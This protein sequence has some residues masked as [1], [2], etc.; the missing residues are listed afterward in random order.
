MS[1]PLCNLQMGIAKLTL[2][3]FPSSLCSVMKGEQHLEAYASNCCELNSSRLQTVRLAAT[4]PVHHSI[5][6]CRLTIKANQARADQRERTTSPQKFRHV[7]RGSS[8]PEA[9]HSIREQPD[10]GHIN[11][12]GSTE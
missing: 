3:V 5:V 12:G 2:E 8:D 11:E 6:L 9:D 4:Q 10:Q 1:C 7:P